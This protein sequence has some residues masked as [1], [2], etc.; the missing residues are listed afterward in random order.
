MSSNAFTWSWLNP[1]PQ[2]NRLNDVQSFNGSDT[3][4]AV[5]NTGTIMCSANANLGFAVG[6]KGTILKAVRNPPL[7]E[8]ISEISGIEPISVFP[9]PCSEY[10]IVEGRALKS[11]S[12]EFFLYDLNGKLIYS[13]TLFSERFTLP[14]Q[15]LPAGIYLMEIIEGSRRQTGKLVKE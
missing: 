1:L 7:V 11:G 3:L 14:T 13:R 5:R 8:S 10:A 6:E 15:N 9:N 2:G 4:F 12:A